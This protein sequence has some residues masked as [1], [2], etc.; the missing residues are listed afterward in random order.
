MSHSC[1]SAAPTAANVGMILWSPSTVFFSS[2]QKQM[3]SC[4]NRVLHPQRTGNQSKPPVSFKGAKNQLS[5]STKE[6]HLFGEK[7]EKN[8]RVF[9]GFLLAVHINNYCLC[10]APVW[11]Q[12]QIP[13]SGCHT[14][15]NTRVLQ[16]KTARSPFHDPFDLIS[17][18]MEQLRWSYRRCTRGRQRRTHREGCP[19]GV[20]PRASG[21]SLSETRWSL[22]LC[23]CSTKQSRKH[24]DW[25]ES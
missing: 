3:E 12:P 24:S 7:K 15:S 16:E 21:S 13:H 8:S 6:R 5:G 9:G 14:W 23:R 2:S 17:V 19:A 11:N 10:T 20:P 22:L 1:W 18:T 25:C 4:D